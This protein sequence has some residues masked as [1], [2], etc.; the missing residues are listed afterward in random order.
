MKSTLGYILVGAGFGAVVS[1]IVEIDN[2]P[3][4]RGWLVLFLFAGGLTLL[5]EHY[6]DEAKKEIRDEFMIKKI[7][8][9]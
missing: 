4:W 9:N 7:M 1:R 6:K 8:D 2:A 3:E 5:L